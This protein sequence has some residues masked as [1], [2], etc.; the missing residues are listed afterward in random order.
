MLRQRPLLFFSQKSIK[1]LLFVVIFSQCSAI[2]VSV[3]DFSPNKLVVLLQENEESNSKEGKSFFDFLEE[4]E[5]STVYMPIRTF[6]NDD[7]INNF[8]REI[9]FIETI[10]ALDSPPPEAV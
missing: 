8:H 6:F 9:F 2:A 5:I 3:F 4:S 7:P 1:C 10:H